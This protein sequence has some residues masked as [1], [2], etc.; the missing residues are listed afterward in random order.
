MGVERAVTRWYV[1]RQT[2]LNEIA[3][4]EAKLARLEEGDDKEGGQNQALRSDS[5]IVAQLNKAQERLRSLGPCPRPM[6]G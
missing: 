2:V 6:M 5:D 3:L 1:H 4:L